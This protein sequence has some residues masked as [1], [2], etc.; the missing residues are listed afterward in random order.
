MFSV[1]LARRRHNRAVVFK[2]GHIQRRTS[3]AVD[4]PNLTNIYNEYNNFK[5]TVH[6]HI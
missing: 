4:F 1:V 3:P 6:L 2:T 5:K